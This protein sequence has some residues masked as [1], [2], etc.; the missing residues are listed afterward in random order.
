[1]EPDKVEVLSIEQ[2]DG[3]QICKLRF[4]FDRPSYITGEKPVVVKK[5][6]IY[7]D[8]KQMYPEALEDFLAMNNVSLHE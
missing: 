1:M 7:E 3:K 5:K 4:T 6:V 2:V 8:V